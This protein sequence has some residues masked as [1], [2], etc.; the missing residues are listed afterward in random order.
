MAYNVLVLDR[1]GE[2]LTAF[3]GPRDR[4][5]LRRVASSTNHQ[6]RIVWPRHAR[7]TATLAREIRLQ[8]LLER[9]PDPT[10]STRR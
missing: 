3:V 1:S 10:P 8:R 6:D 2:F 5:V 4:P 7:V 9:Q